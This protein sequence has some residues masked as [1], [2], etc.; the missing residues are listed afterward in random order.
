[1]T[2]KLS[3]GLILLFFA[4][5]LQFW[6]ASG[7][8]FVD[9]AYAALISFAFIFEFWE[10]LVLVFLGVFIINWQPAAS[11]EIL[12]FALYPIVAYFFRRTISWQ[13]WIAAPLATIVGFLALYLLTAP[14]ALVS[15]PYAFF[16][17]VGAGLA[18]GMVLFAF[19]YHWGARA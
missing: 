12:V 11:I 5:A 15:H 13:P 10:L 7:G 14:A 8:I 17:D 9:L 19:L 1:M 6:F 4:L 18:F 16:L 3:A 2:L